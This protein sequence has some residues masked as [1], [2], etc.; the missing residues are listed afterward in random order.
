MFILILA[1]KTRHIT[2]NANISV[3]V[4][5]C[6]TYWA[7][8][9]TISTNGIGPEVLFC[10]KILSPAALTVATVCSEAATA[11]IVAVEDWY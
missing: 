1:G 9:F 7:A 5:S 2:W 3:L 4:I 11:G 8:L 10:R 6:H